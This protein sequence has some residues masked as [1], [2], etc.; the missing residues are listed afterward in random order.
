MPI[1]AMHRHPKQWDRPEVFDPDR[2]APELG[3]ERQR[4]QYM[5]FGAG[6]RICIG[7]GFAV[8]EAVAV[9]ATLIREVQLDHDP[10]HKIRPL[11]RITM[12]PEG[13][14]PMRIAALTSRSGA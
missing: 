6:L 12:R 14:M 5:P 9:L 1:Y 4:Y 2:F 7:M 3:L 8:N 13:G 10:A 11:V